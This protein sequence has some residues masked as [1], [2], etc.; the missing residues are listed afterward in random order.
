MADPA[1]ILIAE[2][3]GLVGRMTELRELLDD[4]A[5]SS[6]AEPD[7]LGFRVLSAAEPGEVVLL[8]QWTSEAALS[9]HYA[10]P[11]YRFYRDQVGPLLARPSDVIVNHV[12][13]SVHARD[14]NL[15]D[16]GKLG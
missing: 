6:A 16:P 7:C 13:S 5:A 14:P 11:H 9:A 1:L 3:H 15:P 8:S 12:S 10:T 4:L 2:L